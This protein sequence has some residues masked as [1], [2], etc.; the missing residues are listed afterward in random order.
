MKKIAAMMLALLLIV[1]A[2]SAL[3]EA[4]TWW[5]EGESRTAFLSFVATATDL[6]SPG[7]I[8]ETDRIAVFDL[9][10]TL[11]GEQYPIYFEW[12]MYVQ[13]VLDDPDYTPTQEQI[14]VAEE[15]LIAARDKSIPAGLE[16]RQFQ[17]NAEVFAGMTTDEYR[18]YVVRFLQTNADRFE[19]LTLGSAWFRTTVEAAQY[20]AAHGF[21]VYVCSGT[22]RDADRMMIADVIGIPYRQIIGSDCY[23]VGSGQGDAA[24]L[25]YQYTPED[26][27]V[28][29]AAPIIKNVKSSKPMQIMQELGQRPVIAFGNSTGDTSMFTVTTSQNPYPAIAFCVVPDDD[30]REVAYPDK[31]EKLTALCAENGWHPISMKH[32]FVTIYGDDVV[33]A[34]EHTPWLDHMFALLEALR[35]EDAA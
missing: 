16:E 20:L 2:S 31:V 14:D 1:L 25:S 9:D 12:M 21:T 13:R 35:M 27:T 30:V 3:A 26:V 19:H 23:T 15:I 11:C 22:D 7:Y 6:G 10:G 24:Y 33:M 34:P 17:C 18:A 29:T 4:L 5:A 32:D 8:P 28:R